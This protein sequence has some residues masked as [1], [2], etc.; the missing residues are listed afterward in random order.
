MIIDPAEHIE[1]DIFR[2]GPG[3]GPSGRKPCR[4]T[5]AGTEVLGARQPT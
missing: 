2:T 1:I 5:T 4:A 3:H